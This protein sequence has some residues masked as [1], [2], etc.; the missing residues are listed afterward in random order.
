MK[1]SRIV[2]PG[3]ATLLSLPV[4]SSEGLAYLAAY[5][6]D[7]VPM[8]QTVVA[9]CLVSK[10]ELKAVHANT[11]VDWER[12]NLGVAARTKQECLAFARRQSTS[13]VEVDQFMLQ[14]QELNAKATA[15]KLAEL[16]KSLTLAVN[17]LKRSH[18]AKLICNIFYR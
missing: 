12:R 5:L 11:L 16:E 8:T 10:P 9:R 2:L 4:R 15:S 17:C 18:L 1:I 7:P 6:C 13:E 14:I 3:I